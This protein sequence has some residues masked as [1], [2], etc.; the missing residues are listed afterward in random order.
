MSTTPDIGIARVQ[1]APDS[2]AGARLL[3]DRVWPRGIARADLRLDAWVRDVAPSTELR[4]WFGH[5]PERWEAFRDRYRAELDDNPEAV[6][7]CLGWCRKGTVTLLFAAKDREHN[8]A[9]VLRDYLAE[10]LGSR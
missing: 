8:Q 10:R 7:R 6:D 3:V 1:D 2:T 5:D 9:V 4:K